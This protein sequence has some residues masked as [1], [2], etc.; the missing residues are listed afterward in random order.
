[1]LFGNST[2]T[3]KRY[4]VC[5]VRGLRVKSFDPKQYGPG[6]RCCP[7]HRPSAKHQ[8]KTA[9]RLTDMSQIAWCA[10]LLNDGLSYG[11]ML[12]WSGSEFSRSFIIIPVSYFIGILLRAPI[13]G[14][15]AI[16]HL[17]QNYSGR[18]SLCYRV[19]EKIN[20]SLYASVSNQSQ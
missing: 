13:R 16:R 15:G 20:L 12:H 7:S 5:T 17:P 8:S 10:C 9:R 1:M 2:C 11:R 19:V 6:R 18:W 3:W 14:D 4:F